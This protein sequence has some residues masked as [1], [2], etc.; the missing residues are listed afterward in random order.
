MKKFIPF[1][2]LAAL[3]SLLVGCSG[4]G[5]EDA[6]LKDTAPPPSSGAQAEEGKAD[7]AGQT[8]RPMEGEK[9]IN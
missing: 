6:G 3:S 2:I 5:N 1:L 9:A 4:G 7:K 8:E